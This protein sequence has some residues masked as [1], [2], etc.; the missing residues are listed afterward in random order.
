MKSENFT[1]NWYLYCMLASSEPNCLASFCNLPESSTDNFRPKCQLLQFLRLGD[2][3][4][5]EKPYRFVLNY[6]IQN[7]LSSA[8]LRTIICVGTALLTTS[9]RGSEAKIEASNRCLSALEIVLNHRISAMFDPEQIKYL[10]GLS[11][12]QLLDIYPMYSLDEL[13]QLKQVLDTPRLVEL[14]RSQAK[15]H[16]AKMMID[17][18]D[19]LSR[20]EESMTLKRK[21]LDREIELTQ[22][23]KSHG[24]IGERRIPKEQFEKIL[25][26]RIDQ[27]LPSKALSAFASK[28]E[29]LFE[30]IYNHLGMGVFRYWVTND[31]P[32]VEA[33]LASIPVSRREHAMRFIASFYEVNFYRAQE[34]IRASGEESAV[35]LA[36][37]DLL[38]YFYKTKVKSALKA[39]RVADL[40]A[41]EVGKVQDNWMKYPHYVSDRSSVIQK[42]L[43]YVLYLRTQIRWKPITE[44]RYFNYLIQFSLLTD[45]PSELLRYIDDADQMIA[46]VKKS[47][48]DDY[49]R[50]LLSLKGERRLRRGAVYN[51]LL[52][53]YK[54]ISAT[55]SAIGAIFGWHRPLPN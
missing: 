5:L 28:P 3:M 52:T 38:D 11:E 36:G 31:Q 6:S 10:S 34:S 42:V 39:E 23:L 2:S 46:F 17:H 30:A 33:A 53:S 9:A 26:S 54:K 24:I 14:R 1:A 8:F 21:Q 25:Q 41:S 55:A 50:T 18:K 12:Q 13:K 16:I 4:Q 47:G 32:A 45:P 15:D 51:L 27:F 48:D 19:L 49:V 35:T 29:E 37:L 7:K 44:T 20:L 40:L 43:P 22:A